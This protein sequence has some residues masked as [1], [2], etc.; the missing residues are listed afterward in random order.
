MSLWIAGC[1]DYNFQSDTIGPNCRDS[2]RQ[3]GESCVDLNSS[4]DH[5]GACGVSCGDREICDGGECVLSCASGQ[6]V[7]GDQCVDTATDGDHCGDCGVTCGDR[8]ICV[9]GGCESVCDDGFSDCDGQCFDLDRDPDHCG[10]CGES[11]AAGQ[12]CEDGQCQASC[13]D[14]LDNCSGSCRNLTSDPD[15]CGQCGSPCEN[16]PNAAAVCVAGSCAISCESGFSDCDGDPLNGCETPGSCANRYSHRLTIQNPL[17]QDLE[18]FPVSF[19]INTS[20]P[21]SGGEMRSDC[22]DIRLFDS[23]KITALPHWIEGEC[24]SETTRIWVRLDQ[25]EAEDT[26]FIYLR[27]GDS[28]AESVADGHAVFDAFDDFS[29][30]SAGDYTLYNNPAWSDAQFIWDSANGWLL[31]D[32]SNDDYFLINEDLPASA[33]EFW[34]ETMGRTDDNDGFG[35]TLLAENEQFYSCAATSDY[36]GVEN[37][38]DELLVRFDG[39]PDASAQGQEILNFGNIVETQAIDT[40]ASL[41]FDGEALRCAYDY[42]RQA[43][44]HG[45]ESLAIEGLG[46]ASLA[47][48]AAARYHWWRVRKYAAE[49]PSVAV[50]GRDELY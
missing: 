12:A 6:Q 3:C 31:T 9:D 44:E 14:G 22:G 34:V 41:A 46:L 15:H 50:S 43:T 18:D 2:E 24:D 23:D 20:V 37:S 38:N 16:A 11:C 25:L 33:D 26:K 48:D 40:V 45:V 4:R 47:N 13:S 32:E 10:A 17:D 42:E 21:I 30:D 7:C 49:D 1:G 35:A 29:T 19:V 8:E 36:N 5:C 27:Y 28:N 39:L